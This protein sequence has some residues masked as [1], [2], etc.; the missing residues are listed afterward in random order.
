MCDHDLAKSSNLLL[1]ATNHGLDSIALLHQA[2]PSDPGFWAS[3]GHIST[4]DL[5]M[6][7]SQ[8]T[9]LTADRNGRAKWINSLGGAHWLNV[10]L[11]LL[12]PVG[13]TA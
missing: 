10:H 9:G 1:P 5:D 12:S 2:L 13:H 11:V 6:A 4:R 3:G 7:E 8:P